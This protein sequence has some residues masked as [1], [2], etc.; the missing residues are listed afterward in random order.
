[1]YP[2]SYET[3]VNKR[4]INLAD[5]DIIVLSTGDGNKFYAIDVPV[6]V[7]GINTGEIWFTEVSYDNEGTWVPAGDS[8]P[9][10][11]INPYHFIVAIG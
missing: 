3:Y 5:G 7:M 1:M 9:L 8:E 6:V 10:P 4:Y 2:V 11:V